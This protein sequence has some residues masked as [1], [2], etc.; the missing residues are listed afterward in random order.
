MKP[1]QCFDYLSMPRR[2]GNAIARA[3]VARPPHSRARLAEFVDFDDT[4]VLDPPQ[5]MAQIIGGPYDGEWTANDRDYFARPDPA[6]TEYVPVPLGASIKDILPQAVRRWDYIREHPRPCP[7]SCTV[8]TFR[9]S[10]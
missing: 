5:P 4:G 9:L 2:M 6:P 7:D 8:A 10:R 3:P 1:E